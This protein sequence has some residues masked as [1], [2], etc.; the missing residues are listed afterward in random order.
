MVSFVFVA[1]RDFSSERLFCLGVSGQFVVPGFGS[2]LRGFRVSA[3]LRLACN[4]SL[5]SLT[6]S[7]AI[8]SQRLVVV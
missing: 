5:D 4:K 6:K 2:T 8:Y 7:L 3:M 1:Y